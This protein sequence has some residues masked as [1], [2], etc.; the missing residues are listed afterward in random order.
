MLVTGAARVHRSAMCRRLV[1]EGAS[2]VGVSAASRPAE[3]SGVRWARMGIR[4]EREWRVVWADA[5]P[6]VAFHLGGHVQW[7][8]GFAS[9]LPTFHANLESTVALLTV[10]SEAVHARVIL[11]GS[12]HEPAPDHP[13]AP[14]CSPYAAAKWAA[15][16]YARMFQALSGS[17]SPWRV[18]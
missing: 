2:V 18:R 8:A 1:A 12:M 5:A 7:L 11:V 16:G 9:V 3:I 13:T 17:R 10:A 4:N 14:P 6:D 15:T